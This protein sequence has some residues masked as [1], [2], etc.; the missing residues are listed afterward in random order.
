MH[1][2]PAFPAIVGVLFAIL[3][4]GMMLQRIRQPLIVG[5]LLIGIVL[6]PQFAGLID[7]QQLIERLGSIG[8]VFL[9]FF[10]GMEASPRRLLARW[11]I[12]IIGTCIQIMISIAFVWLLGKWLDWPLSRSVLL[13]F[14]ISLSSTAVVLK[15]LQDD[16]ELGS[17]NGQNVLGVLL[18]QDMAIIPMLIVIGFMSGDK[19]DP[20]QLLLQL[21]GG[22]TMMVLVGYLVIKEEIHLPLSTWLRND[23]EMQVF[24]ALIICFGLSLVTG[25]FGLS[26]ALGAFIAGMLVGAA[27]ETQ[28]VHSSL[29][30]FRVIFVALFFVSIGMLVD[31]NF[32]KV[33]WQQ[34]GILVIAVIVTNTFINAIIFRMLGESWPDSF[35]S[36]TLLSQ[37]GEFSFVLAAVGLQ[38]RLI[39]NFGYQLT[40]MVIAFSL[41]LS[42]AWIAIAKRLLYRRPQNSRA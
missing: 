7:D 39:S 15:I 22:I 21:T 4:A 35:Y 31:I 27:R 17:E 10:V 6:G 1:L 16:R 28:W 8:V 40:V 37:I 34:I 2:D 19:P 23:H 33:H 29:E 32:L 18:F 38:A 20:Q 25:L 30:P 5:Y 41:M 24:T 9:L 11:R 42:P 12:A 3:L 13:G 36:G 14:V 26:T